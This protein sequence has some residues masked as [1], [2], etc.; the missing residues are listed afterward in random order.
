VG[1][2]PRRGRDLGF[3]D[4]DPGDDRAG[5][6]LRRVRRLLLVREARTGGHLA[7]RF[8]VIGAT[9]LAVEKWASS[10]DKLVAFKRWSAPSWR[11]STLA[12]R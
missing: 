6:R 7:R 9:S 4:A 1:P 12:L 10:A 2:A 8:Q 5:R 3:R 11:A